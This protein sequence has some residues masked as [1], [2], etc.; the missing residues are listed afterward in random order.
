MR[1]GWGVQVGDSGTT[2]YEGFWMFDEMHGKGRLI[3]ED[4]KVMQGDWVS[5]KLQGT[6]TICYPN[7]DIFNGSVSDNKM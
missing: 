3:T 1:H 2:L 6:A 5:G 4:G 7:G